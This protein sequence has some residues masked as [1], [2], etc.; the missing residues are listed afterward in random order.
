MKII[1]TV[2]HYWFAIISVLSFLVGWGML[3]HSLKPI[4]PTQTTTLNS[5][6][7]PALPT[8]QAFG[9]GSGNGS[10]LNFSAPS[11]QSNVGFPILKTGGS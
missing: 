8:I 2:L 3:A 5:A 1:K 6:S 11:N 9:G 10:G 7:L 4:Q